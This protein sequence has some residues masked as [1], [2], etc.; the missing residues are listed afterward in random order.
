MPDLSR[1]Y[2]EISFLTVFTLQ[3]W[4]L[5]SWDI[6]VEEGKEMPKGVSDAEPAR[7]VAPSIPVVAN[8]CPSCS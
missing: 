8:R 5:R 6:K 3:N 2:H 4:T 1:D 7:R